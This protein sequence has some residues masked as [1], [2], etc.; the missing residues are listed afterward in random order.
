MTLSRR[1]FLKSSGWVAAGVTIV[2]A[3]QRIPFPTL[4]TLRENLKKQA[5]QWLQLL[6]NGQVRFFLG[7]AEMG[8]GILSGLSQL[9]AEEMQ[10]PLSQVLTVLPDTQQI[11]P[12]RM[13]VGSDSMQNLWEP[14]RQ[15]AAQLRHLLFEKAAVKLDAPIKDI[16]WQNDTLSS[17]RSQVTLAELLESEPYIQLAQSNG[18]STELTSPKK[19]RII[20]HAV[21]RKDI[22]DKVSG[23]T[24]Y[25]QDLVLPNMVFG[26]VVKPPTSSAK[27][28]SVNQGLVESMAGVL[29]VLVNLKESWVGIVADTPFEL[30]AAAEAIQC[31]W[32]DSESA[33]A[34]SNEL[35]DIQ[36]LLAKGSAPHSVHEESNGVQSTGLTQA[37]GLEFST[38]FNAHGFMETQAAVAHVNED[39]AD[40]WVGSQDPFFHQALV[41]K[42]VGM[43]KSQVSVHPMLL[44]GGFG[45]KVLVKA[46]IEAAL[47]SQIVNLPVKVIW[48]REESFQQSY[49][50]SPSQH[51]IK[52]S[53]DSRG[54]I[55]TWHHRLASGRVI[56]PI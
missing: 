19:F 23:I 45:G 7:K 46:A 35:L 20:G 11:D 12:M 39:R 37:I 43:K 50:R 24:R 28:V 47:L 48:S 17:Q 26:S 1:Q 2:L 22:P 54:R 18:L 16:Q 38:P 3:S 15:A 55:A 32:Q 10:I 31:V 56:F 51:Q 29:K 13:T 49:F 5:Y 27:L 36:S 40:V 6:P 30:K 21:P 14:L 9:V 33:S 4:P 42:A 52:A 41:A 25:T 44:G 53:I 8:Q 34:D